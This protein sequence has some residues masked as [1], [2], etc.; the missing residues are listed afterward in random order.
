[1][2][3]PSSTHRFSGLTMSQ[4]MSNAMGPTK[5]SEK[6]HFQPA[7]SLFFSTHGVTPEGGCADQDVSNGLLCTYPMSATGGQQEAKGRNPDLVAVLVRLKQDQ[8]SSAFKGDAFSCPGPA[9]PD[10][11]QQPTWPDPSEPLPAG[12]MSPKTPESLQPLRQWS[13]RPRQLDLPTLSD[14]QPG[15]GPELSANSASSSFC[16]TPSGYTPVNVAA[17]SALADS[18]SPMDKPPLPC[19]LGLPTTL[20]E[21]I[22]MHKCIGKGSFGEVFSGRK[23]AQ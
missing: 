22:Q 11:L 1:M 4:V 20:P 7:P 18:L 6:T 8:E 13:R 10:G 14:T 3:R 16:A 2:G 21:E 23:Q 12:G 15:S 9:M 19:L 5:A 17:L